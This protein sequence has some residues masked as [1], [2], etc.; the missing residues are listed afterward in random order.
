MA[1]SAG[2]TYSVLMSL[3]KIAPPHHP[4]PWSKKLLT[5]NQFS[6]KLSF[7]IGK[8]LL[9]FLLF[10]GNSESKECLY[11]PPSEA[12]SPAGIVTD[13]LSLRLTKS[14]GATPNFCT[15]CHHAT[16]YFC[17]FWSEQWRLWYIF[18]CPKRRSG[19]FNLFPRDTSSDGDCLLPLNW[20][21]IAIFLD[22]MLR[23]QS[24]SIFLSSI[25]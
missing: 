15:Y 17:L 2:F 8:Q 23:L 3:R 24:W 5:E 12:P 4:F 7:T 6:N 1:H 21:L 10:E 14:T 22:A 13:P 19:D 16:I 11:P 9:T 18:P 20:A 25:P